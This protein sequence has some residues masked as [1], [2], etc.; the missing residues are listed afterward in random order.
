MNFEKL[1]FRKVCPECSAK[2]MLK[3]Y[4]YFYTRREFLCSTCRSPL[5]S[6]ASSFCDK[7]YSFA[8]S[9]LFVLI[10]ISSED[11]STVI[12]GLVALL[13]ILI[14]RLLTSELIVINLPNETYINT[15]LGGCEKGEYSKDLSLTK[16]YDEAFL[17]AESVLLK[18]GGV[19]T[20]IDREFGILKGQFKGRPF[21]P[22]EDILFIIKETEGNTNISVFCRINQGYEDFGRCKYI[23]ENLINGLNGESVKDVKKEF[24]LHSG[25]LLIFM[26]LSFISL[27][28]FVDLEYKSYSLIDLTTNGFKFFIA[29]LCFH[30]LFFYSVK[31]LMSK[32]P[33]FDRYN[34]VSLS[35]S[36]GKRNFC[37]MIAIPLSFFIWGSLYLTNIK[38]DNSVALR[39]PASLVRYVPQYKE[40][41]EKLKGR[42]DCYRVQYKGEELVH[43]I[44][45][46]DKY[47]NV[48]DGKEVFLYTRKGFFDSRWIEKFDI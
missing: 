24:S 48:E 41:K 22:G 34:L 11:F 36:T 27:I 39:E 38:L 16:A 21:S 42:G 14:I 2:V 28:F 29:T 1:S 19:I 10:L 23:V 35:G 5:R 44:Y 13:S 45:C 32:F 25:I 9:M 15:W 26:C 3:N 4:G 46:S 47:N 31:H 17:F 43:D 12:F 20:H 8:L 6:S 18:V 7:P 40:E 30:T 37:H 33:V